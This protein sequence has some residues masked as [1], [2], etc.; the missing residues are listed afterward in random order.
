MAYADGCVFLATTRG[1]LYALR[2]TG[3]L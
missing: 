3:V 2:M 1:V